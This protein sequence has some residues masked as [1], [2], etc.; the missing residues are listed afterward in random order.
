M[1]Y[2]KIFLN[3][4]DSNTTTI[5]KDILIFPTEDVQK[6]ITTGREKVLT[7]Q[8]PVQILKKKSEF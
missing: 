7:L 5:V 3:L 1:Y 2:K 4:L 6:K 8:N